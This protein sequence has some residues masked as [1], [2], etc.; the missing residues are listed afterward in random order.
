MRFLQVIIYIS[1]LFFLVAIIIKFIKIASSPIHLRW[2]LYPV[3]HEKGRAK[4]GGSRMEE[5]DW[6]KKKQKKDR[7]GEWKVLIPEIA[8]LKGVWDHN[9]D[10]WFGSFPFH[11][12]LYLL[13]VNYFLIV[14][15]I[16]L[17]KAGV[18]GFPPGWIEWMLA[19]SIKIIEWTAAILG[20]LGAIRLLFSRIVDGK[21]RKYSTV[22]H[23]FNIL[24]IGA[25]YLTDLLWLLSDKMYW[26]N[27]WTIVNSL[28][29]FTALQHIPLIGVINIM[30]IM[31][32]LIY[33][34]FTHMTHFFTKYFT[35]H[36]VRWE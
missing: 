27:V 33:L 26:I 2:E 36:K 5:V 10:L 21:L 23:Y 13:F 4:W 11:F 28:I 6:W 16:L 30:L 35:Y 3:P 31:F 24:L 8:L 1:V 25:I 15:S 17:E 32:F 18:L 19:Y 20:T 29:T 34:P 22:S 9:K 14:L 7:L 12:A